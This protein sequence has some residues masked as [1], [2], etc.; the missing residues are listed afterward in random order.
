MK[1]GVKKM[2][3]LIVPIKATID[4]KIKN[5]IIEIEAI[6]RKTQADVEKAN[7]LLERSKE[8]M[9]ATELT[10]CEIQD[11]PLRIND[12]EVISLREKLKEFVAEIDK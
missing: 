11:N 7:S 3:D 8:L 4:D 2:N 9:I 6:V 1:I 5:K 12:I 10:F